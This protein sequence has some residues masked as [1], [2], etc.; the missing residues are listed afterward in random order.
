MEYLAQNLKF[1]IQQKNISEAELSRR[2]GVTQPMINRIVN[3]KTDN[4]QLKTMLRICNYFNINLTQLV[5]I[6][7]A[8]PA[9][10]QTVPVLQNAA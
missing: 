3:G 10:I 7:L 8:K 1:L 2:C 5:E 6:P 4:P 9:L